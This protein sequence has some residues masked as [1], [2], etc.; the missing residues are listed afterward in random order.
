VYWHYEGPDDSPVWDTHENNFRHLRERLA[1]P[2]DAAVSCL[3]DDLSDRGL[4]DDTLVICL[5]EFG[6]TPK[7]NAKAGRDHWPH[8]Q[9]ALLAGAGIPG[10]T[11]YGASDPSGAYPAVSPVSAEDFGTTMLHLLGVRHEYEIYDPT[12]RPHAA[13]VGTVVPGLFS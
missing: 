2:T 1:A 7:I 13:C 6:R 11:V 3:L 8:V 10:G 4:L 12:G 9:A 5:G